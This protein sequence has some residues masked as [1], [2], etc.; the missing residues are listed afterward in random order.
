LS[1]SALITVLVQLGL[2]L[3]PP[4]EMAFKPDLLD[5]SLAVLV[6]WTSA[7]TLMEWRRAEEGLGNFI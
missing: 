1:G 5:H 3:S 6:F 4:G 2:I 7:C